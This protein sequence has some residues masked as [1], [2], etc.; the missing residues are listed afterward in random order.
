MT[1]D[2][3]DLQSKFATWSKR[4]NAASYFADC[5]VLAEAEFNARIQ[6]PNNLAIDTAFAINTETVTPPTDFAS[7]K[8]MFINDASRSPVR[9][10]TNGSM[11]WLNGARSGTPEYVGYF[12]R[13]LRFSPIPSAG[14]TATFRYY[15][16]IPPLD[17]VTN[18]TNWLIEEFPH[19]YLYGALVHLGEL[20]EDDPRVAAWATRLE[21][22]Y[23]QIKKHAEALEYGSGPL[24]MQVE[25]SGAIDIYSRG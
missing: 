19:A 4:S 13:K 16:K 10:A 20:V 2:I 6:H 7:F 17:G 11:V 1:W 14:T 18:T 24:T 23:A 25:G 8:D 15:T 9:F 5:I 12:E 22:V 3:S 21:R